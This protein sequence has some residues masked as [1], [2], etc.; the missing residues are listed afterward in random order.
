MLPKNRRIKR[1][2]FSDVLKGVRYNS[3]HFLIY[4][5]KINIEKPSIFAFSVSKKVCNNAVDRNRLRRQGY[6]V[7][8]KN[9]NSLSKGFM[10]FFLFKKG[11]RPPT[12]SVLEQEIVK[13]LIEIGVLQKN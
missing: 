3:P 12:F 1:E 7:I 8:S 13:N 11:Q 6:S 9:I 10:I 5:K 4:A 2:I